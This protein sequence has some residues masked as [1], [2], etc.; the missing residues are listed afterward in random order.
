MERY[1][2]A[3]LVSAIIITLPSV[4][5][6]VRGV[7]ERDILLV[8]VFGG[9]PALWW[10]AYSSLHRIRKGSFAFSWSLVLLVC[11]LF[12]A[13][14]IQRIVFIVRNSGMEGPDGYGSPLAFLIGLSSELL[15]FMVFLVVAIFG[16][17]V[18][19]ERRKSKL[20]GE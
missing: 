19:L 20:D 16:L 13:R 5:A 15:S 8:L 10:F 18:L 7:L 9:I 2:I 11:L 12:M 4:S 1:K 3:F 6:L 17:A 14:L